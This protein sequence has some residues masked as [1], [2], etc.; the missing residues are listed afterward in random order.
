MSLPTPLKVLALLVCGLGSGCS[1][2][3]ERV[4]AS[5][6]PR[7]AWVLVGNAPRIGEV[8]RLDAVVTAPPGYTPAPFEA[9]QDVPGFEVLGSEHRA[10]EKQPRRWIHRTRLRLRARDVGR[11]E[12]PATHIEIE[13]PEGLQTQLTLEPLTLEVRSV[14]IE[15]P[16]RNTPYGV[17]EAP[18]APDV[19]GFARG[20]AV[21]GLGALALVGLFALARRKRNTAAPSAGSTRAPSLHDAPWVEARASLAHARG[22]ID[23][24]RAAHV[25][26]ETLSLYAARRFGADTFALTT[27]ELAVAMP[28]L[29]A[30]SSWPG[31]VKVL[32]DL[33]ALRF[34]PPIGRDGAAD[35][36]LTRAEA[37]VD[38]TTPSERKS[39]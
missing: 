36:L 28:P 13:S 17:I 21:G 32:R 7:A 20:V 37:F 18:G 38:E 29:R 23:P 11:F 2:E 39:S 19:G 33:D 8:A 6:H 25:A 24:L 16:D 5:I 3:E 30:T 10:V 31:L 1:G 27:E 12:W 35:A 22:E 9:P 14:M 15:H 26:A 4:V 34:R